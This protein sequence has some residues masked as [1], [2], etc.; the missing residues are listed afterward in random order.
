MFLVF[1]VFLLVLMLLMSVDYLLPLI[2]IMLL[3]LVIFMVLVMLLLVLIMLISPLLWLVIPLPLHCL[4]SWNFI[5]VKMLF[6]AYNFNKKIY[7]SSIFVVWTNFC[8]FWFDLILCIED[9]V[10]IICLDL[11]IQ[12]KL[13]N[14]QGNFELLH[15]IVKEYFDVVLHFHISINL[16]FFANIMSF[17]KS[18]WYLWIICRCVCFLSHSARLKKM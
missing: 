5:G 17:V 8:S 13:A 4:I 11:S 3:V 10:L 1:I 18:G 6:V 14:L 16:M 12:G 7:I 9:H 15:C 2:F